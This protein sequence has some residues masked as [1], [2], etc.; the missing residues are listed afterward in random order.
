MA[1]KP[2]TLVAPGKAVA[3][4]VYARSTDRLD[5]GP[6]D[7]PK[8]PTLV[9]PRQSRGA[10]RLRPLHRS[11][12]LGAPRWPQTPQRSSRP[13]KAVAL[14]VYARSTLTAQTLYSG[15]LD[16]GSKAA[17]L[18]KFAADSPSFT[19]GTKIA[20]AFTASVTRA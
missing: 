2:P 9:A 18:R 7:G 4:L 17:F 19:N 8:P 12:G 20:P 11:I 15:I 3:L 5:W 13:G 16:D 10:P 1:P 6:R 14:L